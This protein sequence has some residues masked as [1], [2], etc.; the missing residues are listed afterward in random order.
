MSSIKQNTTAPTVDNGGGNTPPPFA[1]ASAPVVGSD[2]L[3]LMAGF[4]VNKVSA[5]VQPYLEDVIK[6][7]HSAG[8][9]TARVVPMVR[10]VNAFAVVAE[11][12]NGKLSHYL[13]KFVGSQDPNDP[14]LLPFSRSLHDVATEVSRQHLDVA[15]I[16][17]TG[18]RIINSN[19][20]PDM[21]RAETMGRTIAN[22]FKT[23]GD[24]S[25][26]Q[27]TCQHLQGN[28]F[29][30]NWDVA[31]V[32]EMV[33]ELS[34]HGV[35]SRIDLG[36]QLLVKVKND[37]SN[38]MTGDTYSYH[39]V[40]AVGGYVDFPGIMPK[41]EMGGLKT[42][43]Q[44]VFNITEIVSNL[45]IPAMTSILLTALATS[46]YN[47][48]SY[49]KQW[50]NLGAGHPNP[51]MLE[52]DRQNPGKPYEINKPDELQ[53]FAHHWFAPIQIGIH[54]QDGKNN[55][56][57]VNLML[58]E[59]M[60]RQQL[61][62]NMLTKFFGQQTETLRGPISNLLGYSI[63][64]AYGDPRGELRDSRDIDYLDVAAAQGFGAIDPHNKNLLL[65]RVNDPI[66]RAQLINS[67]VGG[68]TKGFR[69]L[70]ETRIHI[71]NAAFIGMVRQ[72]TVNA[73]IQIVDPSATVESLNFDAFISGFESTAGIA[74]LVQNGIQTRD[75][76]T[77]G[78]WF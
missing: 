59:D 70:W 34:P 69:P 17:I 54:Y 43:I 3:G 31:A 66:G 60:Q 38:S 22:T 33:N 5:E 64:G 73:G 78:T 49:L 74:P 57:F 30:V 21:Q 48:T 11:T 14:K 72:L 68:R 15:K 12:E 10:N 18:G 23:V 71:L 27:Y 28:V 58:S 44:P 6:V 76:R 61:Y 9:T 62:A 35:P 51:G 19:Y 67:I 65:R 46:L 26:M 24:P 25:V 32:R 52:E 8:Y 13:L 29:E 42:Y 16:E 20:A 41:Q 39:P 40:G 47:K 53:A 36:F 45:P 63:D 4:R 50:A 37:N 1:A 2:L 7:L 55:L 77:G 56:P 75:Y